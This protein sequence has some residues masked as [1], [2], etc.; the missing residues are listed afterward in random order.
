MKFTHLNSGFIHTFWLGGTLP[1]QV[2]DQANVEPSRASFLSLLIIL[3]SNLF[4]LH[5]SADNK[6]RCCLGNSRLNFRRQK[7]EISAGTHNP[8]CVQDSYSVNKDNKSQLTIPGS[9]YSL[10]VLTYFTFHNLG[11]TYYDYYYLWYTESWRL[12]AW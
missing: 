4:P 9:F 2:I 11:M 12:F 3:P 6:F 10:S 7:H 5:P 1:V 8:S